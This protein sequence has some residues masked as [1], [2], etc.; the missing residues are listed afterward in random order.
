MYKVTDN[1]VKLNEDNNNEQLSGVYMN[2]MHLVNKQECK[3]I[4][5]LMI[6]VVKICITVI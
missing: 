5:M 1:K 6:M 2:R 4:L 3:L